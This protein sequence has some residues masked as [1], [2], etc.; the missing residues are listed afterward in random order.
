MTVP[1]FEADWPAPQGV[2]VVS[3]LRGEAGGG[4]SQAP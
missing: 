1:W 3:T 4:A 2:R